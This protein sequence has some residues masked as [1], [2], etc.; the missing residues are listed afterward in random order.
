MAG[1]PFIWA[2]IE[3]NFQGNAAEGN[4]VNG[5]G[6][7]GSISTNT[8]WEP[9]LPYVIADHATLEL[10]TVLAWQPGV[11]VKFAA[12][13]ASRSMV[14]CRLKGPPICPSS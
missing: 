4:K 11:V 13:S 9:D 12:G 5:I 6:V 10:N 3:V 8:T 2:A 1:M 14:T 7:A